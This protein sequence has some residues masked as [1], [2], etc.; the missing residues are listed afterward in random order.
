[1]AQRKFIDDWKRTHFCGDLR[2]TDAGKQVILF[3]WV[4]TRRNLGGCVFVD[5][6]DREGVTQVV[7]DPSTEPRDPQLDSAEG[8]AQ[9]VALA[10]QIRPEWVIAIRGVVVSRGENTN[11]K[12]PT[13]E[14]E[15]RVLE[16]EVFNR[17][18]TPPFEI[19]DE[20]DTREELRL[21]YRFLD[22]RRRPM[23]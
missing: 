16:A 18:E 5:L 17:A 3:G 2:G 20:L 7:F 11:P 19:V 15:V 8:I 12:M 23:Q 14:I 10:E 4:Q 1:M 21:Q 9:T 6:R 13:G 22:L